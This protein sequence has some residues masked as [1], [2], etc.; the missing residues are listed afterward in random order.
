MKVFTDRAKELYDLHAE[1]GLSGILIV[2]PENV[3]YLT[4]FAHPRDAW[5]WVDEHGVT[6]LTGPLYE[7]ELKGSPLPYRILKTRDWAE[8]LKSMAN[9]RIGFEADALSFAQYRRLQAAWPAELVPLEDPLSPLRI[10]KSPEEVELIATAARIA[11]QALAEVMPMLRPGTSEREIA[12]ALECSMKRLGAEGAA[13]D[14]I[15]ASGE[16]GAYPHAEASERRLAEG[17][18]VTIDWG[19]TYR[20]YHSDATRTYALGSPPEPSAQILRAVSDAEAAALDAVRPGIK[21]SELDALARQVLARYGLEDHFIH[22]LGHGVGLAVHEGP[23]LARGDA[24]L[25]EPGMVITI[26]PGVYVPGVGGARVEDLVLVTEEGHRVLTQ[27]PKAIGGSTP[28][29]SRL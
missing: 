9:G 6:L 1:S 24:T 16:R 26:E 25:L 14:V 13:F 3:R 12:L 22:A 20:G 19:A 29:D 10:K 15:V 23:R 4:G 11:D 18:L 27:A 28:Q 21:G 7:N 2:S 17:E 8:A 5:A